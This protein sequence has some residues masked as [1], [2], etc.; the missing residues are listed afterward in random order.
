M[1][2]MIRLFIPFALGYWL[3]YVFRV[4]NAVVAPN[5]MQELGIDSASLGFI[6]SAYFLTFAACQIPLGILLDRY[7]TRHVAP[8]LLLFAAAGSLTFALANS[9]TLLWIG[10]GLIGMGVSA[11]LMAA[12]K[13]YATWL[14]TEQLPLINGLQLACGGLGALTAT[15]PAEW[16]LQHSDWRTLFILLALASLLIAALLYSCI[17]LTPRNHTDIRLPTLLRQTLAVIRTPAFYQLAPA[18]MLSQ[19][20]FIATQSL[21]AGIWL[22]RVNQLSASDAAQMLLV[23]A[24]G[25]MAGFLGLGGIA[26]RL[27]RFGIGTQSIS[28]CGMAGF[29][30]VLLWIQLHPGRADTLAWAAF[31]FFG[32]SGTLMFAGLAQQFPA[33]ISARVSTSLNLGIFLGAFI[34]QWGMGAIIARW[35]S[36]NGVDYSAEAYRTALGCATALQAL[37]LAWYLICRWRPSQLSN[38]DST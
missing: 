12:F 21:W 10:R 9:S 26:S 25:M 18:S 34:V 31:G 22:Q 38:A 28:F 4:I 13:S 2:I 23:S 11:C 1:P 7:Q 16:A 3:S 19:S 33:A 20:V 35:P 37:S 32:T 15:A 14:K 24:L 8:V 17:P 6:S 5:I 29:L 36:A 30:L 27:N